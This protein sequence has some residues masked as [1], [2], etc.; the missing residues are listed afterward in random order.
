MGKA[1]R[2]AGKARRE[3]DDGTARGRGRLVF[4]GGPDDRL[5]AADLD[6]LEGE[7][8]RAGGVDA[9]GAVALG[10]PQDPSL[11]KLLHAL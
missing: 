10:Q 1:P 6:E 4:E 3:R 8:T 5:H 9:G 7:G 11:R 2:R